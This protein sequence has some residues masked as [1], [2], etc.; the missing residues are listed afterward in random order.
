M[1]LGTVRIPRFVKA[2][3]Q[4]PRAGTYQ[5]RLLGEPV[6]ANKTN[7][8]AAFGPSRPGVIV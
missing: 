8:A 3:D 4:A 1:T 2:N 6:T 5:L 7:G